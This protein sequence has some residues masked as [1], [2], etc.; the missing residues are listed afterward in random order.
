MEKV[1]KARK[2]GT[3]D[4]LQ[5]VLTDLGLDQNTIRN[6]KAL[7]IERKDKAHHIRLWR[8]HKTDIMNSMGRK[9]GEKLY[10]TQTGWLVKSQIEAYLK[11]GFQLEPPKG[12]LVPYNYMFVET[13]MSTMVAKSKRA[14][15]VFDVKED[16]KPR[17]VG[18]YRPDGKMT[19]EEAKDSLSE[20]KFQDWVKKHVLK[21]LKNIKKD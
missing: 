6:L 20:A 1:G 7:A 21:G 12:V 9:V 15:E 2:A 4:D 11:K 13:N 10:W 17:E 16:E 3:L 18:V 14:S 19:L 5:K 8:P